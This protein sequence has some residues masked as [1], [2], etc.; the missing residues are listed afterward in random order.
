MND[1]PEKPLTDD[2]EQAAFRQ[3][4]SF[5]VEAV[6][7]G[8]FHNALETLELMDQNKLPHAEAILL[9]AALEF[10]VQMWVHRMLQAGH[11]PKRIRES[12][13]REV[14][15]FYRKHLHSEQAAGGAVETKQ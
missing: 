6:R 10:G 3:H 4:L 9:T 5:N 7:G 1:T 12:M 2:E 14:N 13:L 8:M 11:P 15:T